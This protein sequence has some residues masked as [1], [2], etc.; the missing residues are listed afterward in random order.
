M[1][2]V[3]FK[4]EKDRADVVAYRKVRSNYA[5]L[6]TTLIDVYNSPYYHFCGDY[7]GSHCLDLVTPKRTIITICDFVARPHHCKGH[8]VLHEWMKDLLYKVT[9]LCNHDHAC[10][11]DPV[12]LD[13]HLLLCQKCPQYR[14]VHFGI[15][16]ISR[17][18]GSQLAW[19]VN[20]T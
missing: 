9:L 1:A 5:D 2:F 6:S 12:F 7:V 13:S 14:S 10:S 3:G 19:L 11:I 16:Q 15:L 4:K 17:R 20:L 18:N 8:R